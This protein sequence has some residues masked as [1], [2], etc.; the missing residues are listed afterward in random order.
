MSI[1]VTSLLFDTLR[2]KL[3]IKDSERHLVLKYRG[4]L[5]RYIQTEIKFL[6]ISALG[7]AYQYAIKIERNLKQKT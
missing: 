4:A 7:A 5:H 6:D 3:G 2:T 1:V